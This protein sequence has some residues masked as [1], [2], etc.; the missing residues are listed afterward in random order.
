MQGRNCKCAS[1]LCTLGSAH[2]LTT[3]G[4]GGGTSKFQFHTFSFTYIEHIHSRGQHAVLL[5][6]VPHRVLPAL[7]CVTINTV[8][9]TISGRDPAPVSVN[10]PN[11]LRWVAP[12]LNTSTAQFSAH[13]YM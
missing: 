10:N 2:F 3:G 6:P 13:M 1:H 9:R 4:G 8:G 11:T 7:K 5:K 12:K